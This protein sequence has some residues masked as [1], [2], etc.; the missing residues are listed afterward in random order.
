MNLTDGAL[1][2]F[3]ANSQVRN[4]GTQAGIT[5]LT[6]DGDSVYGTGYTF[7]SGGN[8]ENSF[9]ASW[10]GGDLKWVADCHGDTYSAAVMITSLIKF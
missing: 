7:G 1:L 4:G 5:S 2:P 10:D 3:G 8:L 6:S 9:R